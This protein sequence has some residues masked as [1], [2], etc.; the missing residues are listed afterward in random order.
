MGH[1]LVVVKVPIDGE[2]VSPDPLGLAGFTTPRPP[3]DH[4]SCIALGPHQLWGLLVLLQG[5]YSEKWMR[6]AGPGGV[7]VTENDHA[8]AVVL[9]L[10]LGSLEPHDST[11]Q[12]PS[13]M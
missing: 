1:H 11:V 6:G 2:P 13:V 4:T 10:G 7:T 12:Q 3:L 8:P 5:L 9:C